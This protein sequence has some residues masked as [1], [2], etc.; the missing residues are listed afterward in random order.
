MLFTQIARGQ[1][2]LLAAAPVIPALGVLE[3]AHSL[4]ARTDEV[5]I[6]YELVAKKQLSILAPARGQSKKESKQLILH[7]L[8]LVRESILRRQEEFDELASEVRRI[9]KE[10][11]ARLSDVEKDLL[12]LLER[13]PGEVVNVDLP[14]GGVQLHIPSLG[15][16][17]EVNEPA[18]MRAHVVICG[19]HYAQLAEPSIQDSTE[20]W[21]PILNL[22]DRSFK[23]RWDNGSS[24]ARLLKLAEAMHTRHRVE[25]TVKLV[26]AGIFG[27]PVGA[28]FVN[29]TV[30]ISD[31]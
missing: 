16:I 11:F 31:S 20:Q 13:Y 21:S 7:D 14:D 18:R 27:Q 9:G 10:A 6:R 3:L 12:S 1:A 29:D 5:V 15:P 26:R 25:L 2:L 4:D 30:Q 24:C 17:K 28:I 19:R 22:N 23:L 8:Q